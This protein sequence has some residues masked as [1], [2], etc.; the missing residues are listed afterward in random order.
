VRHNVRVITH[1][2]YCTVALHLTGEGIMCRGTMS[3][4]SADLTFYVY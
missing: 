1:N 4:F 2:I 3:S